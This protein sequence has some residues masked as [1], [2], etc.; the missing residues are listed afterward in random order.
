MHCNLNKYLHFLRK[1]LFFLVIDKKNILKSICRNHSGGE[2][3]FMAFD[4]QINVLN[5][6]SLW[7]ISFFNCETS[8]DSYLTNP[9][10]FATQQN[11]IQ[12]NESGVVHPRLDLVNVVVRP[13]L[14]TKLSLF[15]KS[16][17]DKE[18]NM[19]KGTWCLFF[20]SSISLNWGSLNRVLVVCMRNLKTNKPRQNFCAIKVPVKIYLVPEY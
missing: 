18:W 12:I 15:N 14:F 19:K 11:V 5:N 8:I 13:L 7:Q 6:S 10:C 9:L 17:V 16:S 4:L 20:K 2:K 3:I 1:L